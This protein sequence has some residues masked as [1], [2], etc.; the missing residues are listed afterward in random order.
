LKVHNE[1]L[2]EVF[3]RLRSYN[4]KLQPDKCK[5]LRRE[6]LYLG[7]HLTCNGLLPDKSKLSA[8]KEFPI[9]TTTKKR[10]GFLGIAGYYRHFIPNFSRTAKRLTN[11]LKNNTPFIWKAKTDKSFNT[12]KRLLTSQPLLQYPDFF[13]PFIL[14]TYASNDALGAVLSQGDIGRDLPVAY[15]SRKLSKDERNYSTVEKE[16]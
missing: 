12:L 11:L 8:V 5:F 6:V 9:H 2:K 1:R 13:K 7:H 10:K 3:A 14:T 4:L 16:L 15:A